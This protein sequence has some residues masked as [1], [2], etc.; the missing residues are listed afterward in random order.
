MA[1]K[2]ETDQLR[3]MIEVV[4]KTTRGDYSGRIDSSIGNDDL[5]ALADA[6]NRM[7]GDVRERMIECRTMENACR[8]ITEKY[9]RFQANIPGMVYLFALHP[10]GSRSFPYV[11]SASLQLF[12]L[13]PE[14]LMRDGSL[15]FGL[16]HP[17]D[18]ERHE[19][20]I[21][22]S[23][24]AL[25]PCREE[26]RYI[27]NGAVRWYECIARPELQISG[28]ILWDGIMLEISERKRAEE[29]LRKSEAKYRRLHATMMDA[30]VRV[31]MAGN[32]REANLAYQALLGYSEEELLQQTNE[33]L[34]PEKW[35]ALE[36]G[37]VAEQ[38]LVNGHSRVYEKEYRRKNG[39]IFPVE[40]RTFLLRDDLGQ[41]IGMWAI[42]RDITERRR[43]EDE[44]ERLE[45][46]LLQAQKMESVGRLAGGVAHDFN[47]MLS[48]ILGYAELIKG[49]LPVGDPH[50]KD[51]LAIE[52]AAGHSRDITRQL[53]AFSRKQI[54]E[55]RL[56]SL[57]DQI[58]SSQNTL[59]R[60]IGEE[61]ELRFYP[62]K[63]LQRINFDPTQVD[64][65][66]VNLVVNARD[67]MP[68]GGRLT[69]ET[70]NIRLDAFYCQAHLGFK[71]GDYVLLAVSDDGVGMDKE[72]QSHLFE[73]F[74][75]TKIVGEGTG[76]GLATVYGMVKQNGGFINVYSEP[77]QG[78]T[79]KIYI[80]GVVEEEAKTEEIEEA[81]VAYGSG[82]VL[83]VEDEEMVREIA[84]EILEEIGY[85]VLVAG[86]P[87][88]ALSLCE[89]QGTRI[90]LLLTD[91]VM[92]GM[93]GVEL[94][95]R[96]EVIRPGIKVLFMSGYTSNVIAQR[97]VLEKG[98]H[99]IQKPF[100]MKDLARKVREA[101]GEK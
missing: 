15:L 50:L 77:G 23:A 90:D 27:V 86:T 3:R 95:K 59:A 9:R 62:E 25:Q 17:D 74:F 75:T 65:I 81:R 38:V 99:F 94:K 39:T 6:I 35:H 41:P 63:D 51:I 20:S 19:E 87:H 21:R 64:Q 96:I 40:Q 98:V 82:R 13:E 2:S 24:E 69:I 4:M 32:I 26:L 42:V 68:D 57:N 16:I 33:D 1:E 36:A 66:L 49:R 52:K 11:N 89:N 45:S 78:T 84:K 58:A 46:Q 43:A 22:R 48:V 34:T 88:A 10:D 79:F 80:P 83:L 29:A 30:F 53:L 55:P 71:P 73:P 61:I 7:V 72:L 8:E 92:P 56:M 31:D 60:L 91:V 93:S 70:A 54:I 101:I 18:Q 85:T 76:L 5:D 100:R 67:A 44:K 14:A 47:N 97:G 12:D 28:D 37:I